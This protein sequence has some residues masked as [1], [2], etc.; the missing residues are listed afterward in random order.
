MNTLPGRAGSETPGLVDSQ[1]QQQN[2]PC[3]TSAQKVKVASGSQQKQVC[4]CILCCCCH[5][6]MARTTVGSHGAM[7]LASVIHC[8]STGYVWLWTFA[9][10][11]VVFGLP[12]CGERMARR[13]RILGRQQG[14]Y[15]LYIPAGI[16]CSCTRCKLQAL[17]CGV[18]FLWHFFRGG[19][20]NA[21]LPERAF[22]NAFVMHFR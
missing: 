10:S 4:H 17:C 14:G 6:H 8:G 22:E 21:W 12:A 2:V 15:G 9:W 11:G 3:G 20:Q 18:P 19:S 1:G 13:T 5:R 16:I 7:A